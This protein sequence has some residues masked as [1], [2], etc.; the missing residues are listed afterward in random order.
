MTD[1]KTLIKKIM[2]NTNLIILLSKKRFDRVHSIIFNLEQIVSIY[3]IESIS[4]NRMNQ[5]SLRL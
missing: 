5:Q 3:R 4:S 1:L 2:S